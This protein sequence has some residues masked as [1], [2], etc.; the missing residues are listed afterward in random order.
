MK[1]KL[2]RSNFDKVSLFDFVKVFAAK[3]ALK[4]QQQ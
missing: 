3:L 1:T 2:L 4:E